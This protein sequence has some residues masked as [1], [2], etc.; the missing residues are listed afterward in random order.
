MMAVHLS[1]YF[2]TSHLTKRVSISPPYYL[3]V[4]SLHINQAYALNDTHL[5]SLG[6]RVFIAEYYEEQ[7][8]YRLDVPCL[9]EP[10]RALS[11][12]H[13]TLRDLAHP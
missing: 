3:P 12:R 9:A 8:E 13:R 11:L 1:I 7:E 5:R 6:S 10:F 4:I 2:Q